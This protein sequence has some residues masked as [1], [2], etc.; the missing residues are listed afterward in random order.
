VP[1]ISRERGYL[2]LLAPRTASTAVAAA[3]CEH[4]DGSWIPQANIY[5]RSGRIVV[6]RK[7]ASADDLVRHGLLS[8]TELRA[9]AIITTVR[10]PFDSLV[11][12]YE[13]KR[14]SYQRL[15]S[16]PDSFVSR[17]RKFSR[18]M[19]FVLERSFSEWV[20]HRYGVASRIPKARWH[21]YRRYLRR[22]EVV[23]RF[24]TIV[25]DVEALARRIGVSYI[26]LE[27]RNVTAARERDYRGYYSPEA[28]AVVERVF[29]PDLER[30]GYS[31]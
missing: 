16:D 26:P 6:Q 3:L 27:V 13:K 1:V 12:L 5:G 8:D 23:M 9:L 15:R 25:A 30:F 4:A 31:F 19:D 7:H 18:D 14:T 24:E 2:F 29:R 20:I 22:A 28:R 11:S 17:N 10:N 21:L